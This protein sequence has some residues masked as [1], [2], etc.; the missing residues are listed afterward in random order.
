M[1]KYMDLTGH[2]YGKLVVLEYVGRNT[3]NRPLWK[4][5]CD[6]GKMH[7]ASTLDLRNGDTISCGCHK[8][9]CLSNAM[10]KHGYSTERL[11]TKWKGI[12]Q[13]CYNPK[14]QMY[15]Y[16]GGKGVQMCEEWKTDYTK[17]R[18]WAYA[19]GFDE[20]AKGYDQTLDRI[21]C[22][23][24]YEPSNCRWTDMTTQSR[25]RGFTRKVTYRGEYLHIFTLADKYHLSHDNLYR[26]IVEKHM[27]PEAAVYDMLAK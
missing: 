24:N 3:S 16:Y 1:A 6:C 22:D 21:D 13:R 15:K 26:R 2:R 25:N 5:Q 27:S 11:Y 17:F 9:K 23:G 18:E 20:N 12:H 10:K 7:I 14:C 19:N 8:A 4:C